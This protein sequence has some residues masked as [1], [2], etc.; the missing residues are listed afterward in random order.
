M[1]AMPEV[2]IGVVKLDPNDPTG[3]AILERLVLWPSFWSAG[4]EDIDRDRGQ[5]IHV[6]A[7]ESEAEGRKAI[8]NSLDDVTPRWREHLRIL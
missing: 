2:V 7:V 5:R 3:D 8:S 4:P 6:G 1:R